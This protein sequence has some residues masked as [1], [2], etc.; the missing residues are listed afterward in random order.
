MVCP[1]GG[2]LLILITLI[3]LALDS[4]DSRRRL[5]SLKEQA[6][7]LGFEFSP[8]GQPFVETDVKGLS[9]LSEDASVEVFDLMRGR[10]G[11]CSMLLFDF[12]LFNDFSI[13]V[14]FTTFA[15]FRCPHGGLPICQVASKNIVGRLHD[16][17]ANKPDLYAADRDFARHFSVWCGDKAALHRYLDSYRLAHL[18]THADNFRL[19]FSPEWILVYR[20]VVKVPAN[21]LPAFIR[22][23]SE[24]VLPLLPQ[25]LHGHP[26]A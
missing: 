15:A 1:A 17:L 3:V 25:E 4:A 8:S 23:T 11:N 24:L 7:R 10:Y 16:E 26:A 19:E 18:R 13:D 5:S 2:G 20:A 14:G 6:R 22:E 9:A 21:E 12:P